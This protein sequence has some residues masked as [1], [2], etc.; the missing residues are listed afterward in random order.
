MSSSPTLGHGIFIISLGRG[1]CYYPILEPGKP[2]SYNSCH[3]RVITLRVR[4]QLTVVQGPDP[5]PPGFGWLTCKNSVHVF[6]MVWQKFKVDWYLVTRDSY[7]KFRSWRPPARFYQD[8]ASFVPWQTVEG[9]LCCTATGLSSCSGNL[10]ACKAQDTDHVAVSRKACPP[11]SLSCPVTC[12]LVI[13]NSPSPASVTRA[14]S[15]AL[16]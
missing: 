13:T 10:W 16:F 12:L 6:W 14:V 5:T 8:T 7:M 3:T 9:S 4:A 1:W 15:Q 2:R 11:C